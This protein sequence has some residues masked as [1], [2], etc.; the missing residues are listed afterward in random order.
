MEEVH[1]SI[2]ENYI[3]TFGQIMSA[4]GVRISGR[5]VQLVKHFFSAPL[6][7]IVGYIFILLQED[8]VLLENKSLLIELVALKNC[9]SKR[10]DH[11]IARD[12]A[13][14]NVGVPSYCISYEGNACRICRSELQW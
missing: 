7:Q 5:I 1:K 14:K 12:V 13:N 2:E 11:Q 10:T 3:S 6:M 8:T 9:L 4:V